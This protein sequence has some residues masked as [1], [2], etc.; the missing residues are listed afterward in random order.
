MI[1]TA[2]SLL[3]GA[4]V[5]AEVDGHVAQ[6]LNQYK[7][8]IGEAIMRLYLQELSPESTFQFE[9]K[10]EA[11]GK[12]LMRVILEW[13]LNHLESEDPDQMPKIVQWQGGQYRRE[14]QK[15]PNRHVASRFGTITLRRYSY[16]WR[17][18][19][20]EPSIFPLEMQLGLIQHATPAFSDT[21]ARE[22]ADAGA[23]QK[24]VLEK[25]KR[26]HNVSLGVPRLRRIVAGE[27]EDRAAL[28][29]QCQVT[30]VLELLE[31]ADKS[32]G[33]RKPVLAVGR[34][35]ISVCNQPYG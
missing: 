11:A 35:G 9:Q 8:L 26:E 24:R 23:S 20:S 22:M 4:S 13:T 17:Q 16:R 28:R 1:Q 25:L 18:R 14:N 2:F 31:I 15:T 19:E 27:A 33:N 34:D 29:H 5:L 10:L 21:V 12:E 7:A 6:V 32:S 30:R 3:V